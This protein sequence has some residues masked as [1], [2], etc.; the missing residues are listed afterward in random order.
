[1]SWLYSIDVAC[2]RF[3]NGMLANP[4][5]DRLMPLFAGNWLFWPVLFTAATWAIWKGGARGRLCVL[6]LAIVLTAGDCWITNTLKDVVARPRP[7]LSIDDVNLPMVDSPVLDKQNEYRRGCSDTGSFPSGHTT[8]W[9]AATF[10]LWLFYPRTLRYML[11]MACLIAFSRVYNGVH[12]PSDVAGGA[13]IGTA[14][15]IAI[16]CALNAAWL[17]LGPKWFPV[18]YPSLPSL[19]PPFAGQ[20]PG[21]RASPRAPSS[22]AAPRPS[23]A[24]ASSNDAAHKETASIQWLRFGYIIIVLILLGRFWYLASGRIELSEDEAYQWL[25]SRHLALSY[26][27]KPPMIAYAQ[28]LGTS[29]FGDNE[30]GVR[31]LSPVLMAIGSFLLLRFFN[32]HVNARAGFWLIALLNLT[33]LL[34]VGSTL[35]T[36][37]PLLVF[38]WTLAMLTGWRAVQVDGGVRHWAAT[39]LFM[40]LAFLSKYTALFQWLCW[41][42]LF[43]I[44]APSRV[45]LRRPGP[46]IALVIN[47]ICALPVIIWNSQHGW[48]TATHVASDAALHRPWQFS[49]LYF[50]EFMGGA[51]GLMHPILFFAAVGACLALRKRRDPL[52]LYFFAMG[53]PLFLVYLFYTLHSRVL[54]NWIAASVIPLLCLTVAY[55][56]RREREGLLKVRKWLIASVVFGVVA[57]TVLHETAGV[58]SAADWCSR[59]FLTKPLPPGADPLR[60][61]RGWSRMARIVERERVQ[62]EQEGKPVFVIGHHYGTTSILSFYMRGGRA[63]PRASHARRDSQENPLVYYRAQKRPRNQ[64]YYWK[65]YTPARRGQNALYVQ[66]KDEAEPPT[67]D[68]LASFDSVELVGSFPVR[69]HGRIVHYVHIY[70]CRNLL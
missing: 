46:Y 61:V 25:W 30:F 43:I 39:G 47:A 56:E 52:L 64:F 28:A 33:P 19:L 26:F 34:A 31:F 57:V 35:L 4:V 12:Y 70:A 27:S 45:H 59:T 29:L 13:V 3:I 9:W 7:C 5:L 36:V 10:V 49:P 2:F 16:I 63:S 44:W 11:P 42:V 14:Y 17:R 32:R 67:Q 54:V 51:V 55:W 60:R 24:Q 62:L 66:E 41:A 20:N 21:G 1:V 15:A 69:V 38:F 18:W 23:Q 53:A 48:I 40:G 37:D 65:T 58:M 68:V 22:P 6:L 8:N 50:V